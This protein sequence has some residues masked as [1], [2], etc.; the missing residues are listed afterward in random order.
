MTKIKIQHQQCESKREQ[1]N[2]KPSATSRR[3]PSAS[4]ASEHEKD[5]LKVKRHKR[6]VSTYEYSKLG[7]KVQELLVPSP[8]LVSKKSSPKR[9]EEQA[10]A[11]L[12][13][14]ILKASKKARKRVKD[15]WALS[16][17]PKDSTPL[18]EL[19]L[20]DY[21]KAGWRYLELLY[22][23]YFAAANMFT[24]L[25][26]TLR[27][28]PCTILKSVFPPDKYQHAV[29]NTVW[30]QSVAYIESALNKDLRKANLLPLLDDFA[31]LLK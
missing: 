10:I 11:F 13:K 7:S 15:K 30:N 17:P 24:L 5:F 1:K 4:N 20:H 3:S 23:P 25:E 9:D 19:T 16:F 2:R 22:S 31:K 12:R 14:H 28:P 26:K 27:L 21:R 29:K 18:E 6:G 8:A